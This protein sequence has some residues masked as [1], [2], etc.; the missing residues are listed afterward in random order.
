MCVPRDE[1]HQCSYSTSASSCEKILV[2]RQDHGQILLDD[3]QLNTS[4]S[5]CFVVIAKDEYKIK[6]ILNQY[7][8]FRH[9]P[10][11]EMLIYDGSE[12]QQL[13]LTSSSWLL[14]QNV[15]QTRAHH[16][17]TIVIRRRV[18]ESLAIVSDDVLGHLDVH[19]P[20]RQIQR[21]SVDATVLNITWI[22]SICPDDQMLCGGHFETKCYTK[23]QRCD[24]KSNSPSF[25]APFMRSVRTGIWDCISGDDELGCSPEACPTTFSCNDRLR[26]PTDQP[27]CFTWSERCN[28]NPF[29]ASRS[30][31]KLCSNWWCNSN[32]GTFLCKNLNC[33]Y[34][35]WVCDG[36]HLRASHADGSS[37]SRALQVRMIVVTTR[38][39]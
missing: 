33:I 17:A 19:H 4:Q 36:K 30:D 5:L 39:K 18:A 22:T 8:F 20:D 14:S 28:G 15:L 10:D 29:C 35:T 31:E 7:E 37:A 23:R 25:L 32:N 21:R 2:W 27:R 12:D 13:P 16:I 34:E 11:L 1:Y 24:G 9:R 26:L 6:F 38:T 3:T